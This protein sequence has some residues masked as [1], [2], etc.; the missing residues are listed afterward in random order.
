MTIDKHFHSSYLHDARCEGAGAGG[1]RKGQILCDL[2]RPKISLQI[3]DFVLP[4]IYMV[5]ICL[6]LGL[7]GPI[8]P[9]KKPLRKSPLILL[10]SGFTVGS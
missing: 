7:H 2:T 10:P 6:P 5:D 3:I 1:P 4:W 9:Q 8:V